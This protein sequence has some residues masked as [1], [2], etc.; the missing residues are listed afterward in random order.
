MPSATPTPVPPTSARALDGWK[1]EPSSSI[2]TSKGKKVTVNQGRTGCSRCRPIDRRTRLYTRHA[3]SAAMPT[4]AIVEGC[5][6]MAIRVSLFASLC[7]RAIQPCCNAMRWSCARRRQGYDNG[8]SSP[9]KRGSS[10]VRCAPR[11]HNQRRWIP[12]FAGM[13]ML[14]MR[15]SRHSMKIARARRQLAEQRALV[16]QASRDQ[17]HDF[18]RAL[19]R[20]VDGEQVGAQKLLALTLGQVAPDD[21]VDHAGLVFQ[22]DEGDAAGGAGALAAGDQSGDA[23]DAAMRQ[24]TQ[25]GGG[26]HVLLLQA[27]AQQRQRMT[28]EGEAEARVIGDKILAFARR[29]EHRRR[30]VDGRILQQRRHA[31]DAA[32]VP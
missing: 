13:T 27:L 9:R 21:D 6:A 22:R 32:D 14:R 12:T 8:T 11:R 29:D 26:A 30:V 18:A 4:V 20:A 25:L 24:V 17:V 10:G 31:L 2:A 7:C 3:I 15:M 16:A 1:S 28:A 19:E 23:R 5:V